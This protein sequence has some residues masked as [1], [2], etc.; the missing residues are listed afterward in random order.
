MSSP[1]RRDFI[2]TSAAAAAAG[3]LAAHADTAPSDA[4]EAHA[5]R[6]IRYALKIG[7]IQ[8]G[9]TLLEKFRIARDAGFHGV[10]LDSPGIPPLQDIR[11]ACSDT[12]LVVPGVVGSFHWHDQLAHPD[13][14]TRRR[15]EEALAV[16]LRD[17]RDVGGTTV[18]LV[19]AV[20]GPDVAY[21][22][23]WDR[24][25]AAI[26]RALPMAEEL[27]VSIA[28]ENV[29]NNF[30]LSPMEARRYVD[31]FKS[32][33]VGWYFDVGNIVAYG[34]PPQWVRILG[35]RILKI[36]VK[37]YSR[38]KLDKEGRWAGF[39]VPIGE[40]D[41]QWKETMAALDEVGYTGWAS[42]EVGGGDAARLKDISS[43]MD[44]VLQS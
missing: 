33:H 11:D 35:P 27:G 15:G 12:G 4:T 39:S 44:S 13:S 20:V 8:E 38:S 23:A 31:Q 43:R 30:L 32:P 28:I 36:D 2:R 1:S 42:A 29:W 5:K 14:D 37:E 9:D 21:D 3:S 6:P 17:C 10:E 40:G 18:L 16:A 25:T 7:M 26:Q 41:C 24:S 34:W 19:P 22:E